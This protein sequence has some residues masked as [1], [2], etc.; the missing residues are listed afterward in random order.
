MSK[1]PGLKWEPYGTM[2]DFEKFVQKVPCSL[3]LVPAHKTR[4]NKIF[5][6]NRKL[7]FQE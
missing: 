2:S 3:P 6:N 4:S 5:E 1:D 7:L